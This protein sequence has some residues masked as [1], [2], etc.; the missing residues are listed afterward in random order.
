MTTFHPF[1]LLPLELRI[2]IW[3]LTSTPTHVL[4]IHRRCPPNNSYWSPTPPPAVTRTSCASHK[5]C[6]Y[7]KAFSVAGSP[8][9]IWVDFTTD[10][11]QMLSSVMYDLVVHKHLETHSITHLRIEL[12]LNHTRD[13]SEEFFFFHK[14]SHRIRKLPRPQECD[15]LVN[16]GLFAWTISPEDVDWGAN[17]IRTV[18]AK[19]GGGLM[20]TWRGCMLIGC[21]RMVGK[22]GNIRGLLRDGMRRMRRMLRGGR[23]R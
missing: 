14:S 22:R 21:I 12:S 15:F 19:T 20:R 17:F 9:C 11:I 8:R 13:D 10:I 4:K 2:Q 5:H 3:S 16:D 1:P 7:V 23:K 6:T 18:Y